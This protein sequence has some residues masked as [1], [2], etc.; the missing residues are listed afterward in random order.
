MIINKTEKATS[1]TKEVI[2]KIMKK[3]ECNKSKIQSY[4]KSRNI[5]TVIM[6][7]NN[8]VRLDELFSHSF[9]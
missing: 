3:F 6:N 7:L 8:I 1:E 4:L 5:V 2:K 9:T